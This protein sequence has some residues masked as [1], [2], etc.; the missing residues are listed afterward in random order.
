MTLTSKYVLDLVK[1]EENL[2][3]KL[4]WVKVKDYS[5]TYSTWTHPGFCMEYS[6]NQAIL[7]EKAGMSE[8]GLH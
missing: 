7:I 2:L 6:R 1:A 5:E 8:L 4:G 3:E